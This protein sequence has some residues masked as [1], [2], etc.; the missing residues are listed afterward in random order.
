[1]FG[2]RADGGSFAPWPEGSAVPRAAVLQTPRFRKSPD[3]K[4]AP[5]RSRV[6][7]LESRQGRFRLY[8]RSCDGGAESAASE[9]CAQCC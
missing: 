5:S 8:E 2:W 6:P 3:A 9:V 4:G 7:W 1:M